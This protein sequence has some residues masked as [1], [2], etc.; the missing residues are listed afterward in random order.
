MG[1]Q[2]FPKSFKHTTK[3]HLLATTP[4]SGVKR[5]LFT[6]YSSCSPTQTMLVQEVTD[7]SCSPNQQLL[8]EQRM[9]FIDCKVI[10]WRSHHSEHWSSTPSPYDV[11]RTFYDWITNNRA[12][13]ENSFVLH[14]FCLSVLN[15]NGLS[16]KCN[17]EAD[18]TE[19]W[20]CSW[21]VFTWS[22]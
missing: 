4:R 2:S 9:C 14:D 17:C 10:L 12:Y 22:H 3:Y 6:S 13:E 16:Y 18:K 21:I 15:T 5:N 19:H 7:T 20:F 8:G 1:H 11:Q